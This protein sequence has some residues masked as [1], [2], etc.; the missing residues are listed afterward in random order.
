MRSAIIGAGWECGS[1]SN[2]LFLGRRRIDSIDSPNR[3]LEIGAKSLP[4]DSETERSSVI[5]DEK[6][7]VWLKVTVA[8]SPEREC[9]ARIS[10]RR[11]V[12]GKRG[13]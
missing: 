13:A 1:P 2:R 7:I 4:F 12:G 10:H 5:L 11:K 3:R 8:K 6:L 9:L